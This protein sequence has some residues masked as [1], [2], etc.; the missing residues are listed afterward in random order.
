M[1]LIYRGRKKNDE[2][3]FDYVARIGRSN[4]YTNIKK[5][6]KS[7]IDYFEHESEVINND[8]NKNA[9]PRLAME[10]LFSR[11]IELDESHRYMHSRRYIW[12]KVSGK[13]E[14]CLREVSYTRFYWR[15]NSYR[16]CHVHGDPIFP[17]GIAENG[18]INTIPKLLPKDLC[19]SIVKFYEDS[20]SIQNSVLNEVERFYVD[21]SIVSSLVFYFS[22][23]GIPEQ[24]ANSL[25]EAIWNAK[26]IGLSASDRIQ[27][28][29]K[30]FSYYTGTEVFWLRMITLTERS[31]LKHTLAIKG[32]WFSVEG[33]YWRYCHF[34][35]GTDIKLVEI[36]TKVS[37]FRERKEMES[38]TVA[39]V[40]ENFSSI[41]DETE[42]N[43]KMAIFAL[44]GIKSWV[45][46]CQ[47]SEDLFKKK[48]P[49]Q[50]YMGNLN[51]FV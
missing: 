37:G 7:I 33:E 5:F 8:L 2:F 39:G 31:Y 6:E 42:K 17:E 19:E 28:I 25:R 49:H 10:R 51:R 26:L 44:R 45:S 48:N 20:D 15:L 30:L 29:A 12:S 22:S 36:F 3:I 46:E 16:Y 23:C 34:L 9:I 4:G 21:Q 43:I 27:N 32:H 13:C 1:K 24:S 11:N 18:V 38:V 50:V 40:I 14:K 47:K 35:M 41:T